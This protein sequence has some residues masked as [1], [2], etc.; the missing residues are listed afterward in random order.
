VTRYQSDLAYRYANLGRVHQEM[1]E[2]EEAKKTYEKA[3][4]IFQQLVHDQSQVPDYQDDLAW[5]YNDLGDFYRST[6][7]PRQAEAAYQQ[8]LPVVDQLVHEHPTIP[9]YQRTLAATLARVGEHVRATREIQAWASKPGPMG[10]ILRWE[11]RVYALACLG[12]RKD[13]N[14]S[15]AERDRLA[16]YYAARA[17]EL[18]AEARANGR[19]KMWIDVADLTKEK[20]FDALRSRQDFKQLLADLEKTKAGEN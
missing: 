8:A 7:Q 20:D 6:G 2:F 5:R 18:L 11:A 17:I 3:L 9:D 1:K 14:L 13:P 15:A 19:F 16:E 10:S 12:A 4:S